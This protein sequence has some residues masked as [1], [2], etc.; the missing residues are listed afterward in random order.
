MDCVDAAYGN[1]FVATYPPFSAWNEDGARRFGQALDAAPRAAARP[2]GL[3]LHI[4]FCEKRCDFCYYLSYEGRLRHGDEYVAALLREMR[5]YAARPAMTGANID[6][7]YFG[8]GTPSVL[9]RAQLRALFEGLQQVRPWDRAREVSFECA[10]R[11]AGGDK[12]RLVRDLGV[13]RVSLGVQEFDDRVLALNGRVHDVA[14]VERAY[15]AIREIGFDVVNLDLIAGLVGQTDSG[16]EAAVERAIGLDPESVTIYQLEIPLNTPLYR[17]LEGEHD[18]AGREP[19][20][21]P[22]PVRRARLQRG[23]ELLERAGYTVRSAYT[24][25][26][27]PRKQGFVYQDEQYRGAD[28]LGLG[29]SSFSC[30]GGIQ[31][32]NVAALD[33]YLRRVGAGELPLWRGYAMSAE[34][35][36]VREFVL[37]LKLGRVDFAALPSAPGANVTERFRPALADLVD[38]RLAAVDARGVTL[39]REGLLQVDRLVPSFYLPRH[40]ELR[41]S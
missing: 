15:E 7:V 27:S 6:F 40:R 28:L 14:H 24:A 34:E 31:Q 22:W 17:S 35:R 9:S 16:F 12:L 3:Y 20:P 13:T 32:Q 2:L 1:Y 39:T 4:P 18:R 10:P 26:K 33:G 37:Q 23:F 38:R 41:Y 19:A 29:A 30:L 8:G 21:A 25:V 5:L 36:L 11:S